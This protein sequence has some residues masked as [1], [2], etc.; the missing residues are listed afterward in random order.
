MVKLEKDE[1]FCLVAQVGDK[2]IANS[3]ISRRSGFSSHVCSLGIAI[4]DGF[5]D[6]GIGTQMMK[7]LISKAKEWG[8][9]LIELSVYASNQRAIHVYKKVGFEEVGRKPNYIYKNDEYID[10]IDMVLE[11]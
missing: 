1:E 3:E 10:L 6:I 8:L 9:K 2:V 11:L 7:C 4:K 5:R